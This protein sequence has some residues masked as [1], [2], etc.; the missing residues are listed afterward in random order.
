[1]GGYSNYSSSS[2]M[3][4]VFFTVSVLISLMIC[5]ILIGSYWRLFEKAGYA[6]WKALIPFYN[7]YI[8]YRIAFG[9]GWL[10]L[11]GFVPIINIV[12]GFIWAY[13]FAEDYGRG[14]GMM[15]GLVFIPVVMYPVLA[16]GSSE[17]VGDRGQEI[18]T[19]DIF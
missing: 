12:V 17:Y 5:V 13:R 2:G 6:G 16:F 8:L 15:L 3:T 9:N 18:G 14:V 7:A 4:S 1:M 10:F 19:V 11:L